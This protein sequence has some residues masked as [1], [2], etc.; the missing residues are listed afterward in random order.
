MKILIIESCNECPYCSIDLYNI[1][2]KLGRKKIDNANNILKECPL[3]D[4]NI[5]QCLYKT[6][7]QETI[8]G[9]KT[10]KE[11]W[12]DGIFHEWTTNYEEL[13]DNVGQYPSAIIETE[14][15]SIMIE[16]AECVKFKRPI[17]KQLKKYMYISK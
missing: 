4:N 15:G 5:Q 9:K 8:E 1:C 2:N 10:W 11:E 3:E 6:G 7:Y 17:K 13:G 16:H 14:D 12:K